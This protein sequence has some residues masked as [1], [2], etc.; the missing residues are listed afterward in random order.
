VTDPE[1]IIAE[2]RAIAEAWE[3]AIEFQRESPMAKPALEGLAF[4]VR[5]LDQEEG[6]SNVR[7]V[8]PS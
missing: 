1:H 2:W 4:H 5:L 6:T 8:Q 3:G 7:S